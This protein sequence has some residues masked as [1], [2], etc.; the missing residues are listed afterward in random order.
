MG[1]NSLSDRLAF[2]LADHGIKDSRGLLQD[3]R[4]LEDLLVGAKP[5]DG[6]SYMDEEELTEKLC[7]IADLVY[8]E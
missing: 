2:L 8:G 4:K 3:L 6:N 7:Q 5:V 1:A